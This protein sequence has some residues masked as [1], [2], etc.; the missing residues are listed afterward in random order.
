MSPRESANQN[1]LFLYLFEIF[2]IRKG[3]TKFLDF[4]SV[5][6]NSYYDLTSDH[7]KNGNTFSK[8]FYLDPQR[9]YI[10]ARL[11]HSHW[12]KQ[13]HDVIWNVMQIELL[14]TNTKHTIY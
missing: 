5:Q 12:I 3:E 8:I 13:F 10:Y 6:Y 14:D 2:E 9:L 11:L 7:I 4:H 1:F